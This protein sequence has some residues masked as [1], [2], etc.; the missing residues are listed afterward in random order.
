MAIYDFF[1]SRN[2]AAS[3]PENYVGH[4]GRL[5]YDSATGVIKLSDGVTPGGLSIPYT[6]ATDTVVGG[7]KA[8]PGVTIN[9]EGQILIDSEGLEFNFGDFQAIVGEYT[10]STEYAL[11]SSVNADEDIVLA[12]SGTGDIKVVGGFEVFATNGT[13]TGSLE[14][15]EPFFRILDDG[16]VRILVPLADTIEGGVE[17]MAVS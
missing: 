3:T 7:V 2:N 11:L 10:N 15:S 1:L 4:T 6:I 17:I 16:Q 14:D 5:F 9:S 12:S 8:G 13:V